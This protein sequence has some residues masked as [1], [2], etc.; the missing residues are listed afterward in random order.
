[1]ATPFKFIEGLD[2]DLKQNLLRAIRDEWT[3]SSTAIEGNTLSLPDTMFVLEEGLTVAGKPIKDHQE[4]IGHARAIDILYRSLQHPLTREDLF[5]LHMAVQTE[6]VSDIYKPDGAWK[7][8]ENGTYAMDNN[9]QRTFIAFSAPDDVS[10]LMAEL[11]DYVNSINPEQVS[12]DDAHEY[13]GIIHA[14]FTSIHPFWDGNGR[15]ARLIANIPLL[16]AGL[17]PITIATAARQEYIAILNAY[18]LE[19]GTPGQ[20]TGV[21][22][23]SAALKPFIRFC[24]KSY[25]ITHDIIA[26]ARRHQQDRDSRSNKKHAHSPDEQRSCR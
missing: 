5:A 11:V 23:N 16:K 1:M 22:P 9:G 13:Y 24:K 21:W 25:I 20:D 14:G 6:K 4:V 2:G 10:H 7:V 8:E 12:I 19:T 17:P 18:Q 15:M 26:A 3:H